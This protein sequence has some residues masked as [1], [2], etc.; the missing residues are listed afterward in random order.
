MPRVYG[1]GS[2]RWLRLRAR[3]YLDDSQLIHTVRFSN[4]SR[5][6][7]LRISLIILGCFF[8]W[9]GT[10]QEVSS[11]PGFLAVWMTM[12]LL[13]L[14]QQKPLRSPAMDTVFAII[15]MGFVV[16]FELRAKS[17]HLLIGW[18]YINLPMRL[19][20]YKNREAIVAAT[21]SY[22]YS[23]SLSFATMRGLQQN[24]FIHN[25][26]NKAKTWA[27]NS[28]FSSQYSLCAM[29]IWIFAAEI[30]YQRIC[31]KIWDEIHLLLVVK[32][33]VRLC[34]IASRQIFE[35]HFCPVLVGHLFDD[36]MQWSER[37]EDNSDDEEEDE[38][39][40]EGMIASHF[41]SPIE[42]KALPSIKSLRSLG[43]KNATVP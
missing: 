5:G 12:L 38:K 13:N 37:Q 6:L 27:T 26:V 43:G 17:Q 23:F 30:I 2:S 20:I 42:A 41:L 31:F 24:L 7:A 21:I 15:D 39:K 36:D 18:V 32:E 4:I 34:S 3:E 25:N 28:S 1:A 35:S 10:P 40:D 9:L 14:V 29:F 33:R 22:F 11:Q 8:A 19:F 16:Y